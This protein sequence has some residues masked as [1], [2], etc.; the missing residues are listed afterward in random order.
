LNKLSE[1]KSYS[2][3]D[4][5]RPGTS[6]PTSRLI[7]L[8]VVLIA[9][10]ASPAPL[11]WAQSSETTG[12]EVKTAF[13]FNFAKFIDWPSSSF[14]S[15]K[16]PFTIC[17]LGHDPFG[18]ILDDTLQ[19]KMIGDRPLA[20]R[21]LKDEAEARSCQMVFV[22]SLESAHLAEILESLRGANILLVG[23]TNG[24]AASGGTIE[25]TLEDNHVRFT[26]N[27]DAADRAGLKFS[28]KLLAL[29][30]IVHDEGHSKGG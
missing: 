14:V 4:R 29:A 12:Y 22:S 20:V 15:P 19:G 6:R 30:K 25:F 23:E 5:R 24:F 3:T 13:L 21:R 10:F 16:S 27:P 7:L 18:N 11:A 26:I 17:V 1:T 9:S 2:F 28:A 8:F